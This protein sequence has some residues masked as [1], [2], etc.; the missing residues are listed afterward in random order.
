[1]RHHRAH[2]GTFGKPRPIPMK[3]FCAKGI[4]YNRGFGGP[5]LRAVGRGWGYLKGV[6]AV[7]PQQIRFPLTTF[8]PLCFGKPLKKVTFI[9]RQSNRRDDKWT[10]LI[11]KG[12]HANKRDQ[13]AHSGQVL[14]I[15]SFSE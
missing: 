3:A 4:Y 15:F 12:F 14:M 11:G 8:A 6:P 7:N 10:G 9:A 1:V 13:F 5:L 2:F